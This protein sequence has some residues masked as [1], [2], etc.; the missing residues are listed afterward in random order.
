MNDW[1]KNMAIPKN[2]VVVRHG[3]SKNEFCL[4]IRK[5]VRFSVFNN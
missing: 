2:I 3:E 1:S 4:R 5:G